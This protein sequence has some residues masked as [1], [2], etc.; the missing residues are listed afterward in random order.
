LV[1]IYI[2]NSVNQ[3]NLSSPIQISDF[4]N[5]SDPYVN[6]IIEIYFL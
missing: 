5:G 2:F 1:F 3:L 6:L 4:P